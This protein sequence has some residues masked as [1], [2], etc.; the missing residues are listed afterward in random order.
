MS[1]ES[2]VRCGFGVVDDRMSVPLE[3]EGVM[4]SMWKNAILCAAVF[5]LSLPVPASASYFCTGSID[6]VGVD[7]DGSVIMSS[8]AAGLS[9]VT[10]CSV[11]TTVNDGVYGISPDACKGVLATLLRAQATG[12]TVQ[13]GF[14]DSLTCTTH[15]AWTQLMGW[16]FGP[17]VLNQ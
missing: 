3:T 15:T 12:A 16:Y 4:K 5:G 8:S 1:R 11:S 10:L 14:L 7:P 13:W 17:I 6:S 9:W 2:A